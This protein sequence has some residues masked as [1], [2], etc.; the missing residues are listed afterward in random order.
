M[1][2]MPKW[3][4]LQAYSLLSLT[5]AILLIVGIHTTRKSV[6]INAWLI[7]RVIQ[8]FSEIEPMCH[9]M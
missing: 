6:A 5:I 7:T 3:A 8:V 1:M 9:L 4:T 2:V